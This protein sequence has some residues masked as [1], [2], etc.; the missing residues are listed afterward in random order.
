MLGVTS[1]LTIVAIGL[2]NRDSLPKIS[3]LTALEIYSLGCFVFV[4]LSFTEFVIVNWFIIEKP[5][6]KKQKKKIKDKA[7]VRKVFFL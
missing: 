3:Y 6:N 2:N 7:T 4:L 1:I 5:R